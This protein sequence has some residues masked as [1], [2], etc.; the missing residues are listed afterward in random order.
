MR[1][2][3]I[4][5]CR[6]FYAMI[7]YRVY[8]VSSTDHANDSV[9]VLL[10]VPDALDGGPWNGPLSL[11]LHGLWSDALILNVNVNDDVPLWK[12]MVF[13]HPF[14]DYCVCPAKMTKT[15]GLTFYAT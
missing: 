11:P 1:S 13:V 10:T 9:S 8:L 4:S 7:F 2:V 6:G 12:M 15:V 3:S 5:F 14:C